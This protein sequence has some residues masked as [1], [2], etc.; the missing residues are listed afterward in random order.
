V[1]EKKI[2]HHTKAHALSLVTR[3]TGVG[4]CTKGGGKGIQLHDEVHDLAMASCK[5]EIVKAKNRQRLSNLVEKGSQGAS[6]VC[7]R[8]YIKLRKYALKVTEGPA[9]RGTRKP[10][11]S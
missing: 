2:T 3:N 9:S 7:R 5:R 8:W 1:G 6:E 11:I 4:G 10:R